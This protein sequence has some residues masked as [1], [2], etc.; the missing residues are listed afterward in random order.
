MHT[1]RRQGRR[2]KLRQRAFTRT[3][4]GGG[5]GNHGATGLETG[6][7]RPQQHKTRARRL[8][9]RGLVHHFTV[10]EI[11]V[12]E[13]HEF[14][15]VVCNQCFQLTL[16]V[17][18]NV[19]GIAIPGQLPGIAARGNKRNLGGGKRADTK[20]RVLQKEGAEIVK[21]APGGAHN[22]AVKHLFLPR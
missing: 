22:N 21:V 14:Y 10:I 1:L 3:G 15:L 8:H 6:V 9:A 16:V 12:G 17:N 19:V 18:R 7:I 20:L 5:D 11:A 13:K 4:A 2:Q